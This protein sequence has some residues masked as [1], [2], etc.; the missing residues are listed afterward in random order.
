MIKV[1]SIK[2]YKDKNGREPIKECLQELGNR[3]DKN[4]RVN[5]NKIRDYIKVLSVYTGQERENCL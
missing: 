4:S 2:F 1:Y 3:T 5:F